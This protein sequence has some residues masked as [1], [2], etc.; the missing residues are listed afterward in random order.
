MNPSTDTPVRLARHDRVAVI[1]ID[2]PPV[3]ALS[4][5]VRQGL[6]DS[7]AAACRDPAVAAIVL[8]CSGK[9]FISGADVKEFGLVTDAPDGPSLLRALEQSDKPVICAMHGHALGGGLE[10]AL[11][12]HWR[13]AADGSR[14]GLPEITLGLLP[15]GGGTQRLPRLVGLDAA[16]RIVLS[17]R[18]VEAA[19]ALELGLL[20]AVVAEPL[21]GKAIAFA[22]SVAGTPLTQRRLSGRPAPVTDGDAALL[23]QQTA[24][25]SEAA[26]RAPNAARRCVE[27]LLASLDADA[28]AGMSRERQL[29]LASLADEESLALRY[30]FLAERAA[31][32]VRGLDPRL[33]PEP[34][35]RVSVVGAGTM[36][37]GIAISCADAGYEVDVIDVDAAAIERAEAAIAAHYTSAVGRRRMSADSAAG[38]LARF[39]Y[40]TALGAAADTDLVIEAIYEDLEAKRTMFRELDRTVRSGAVLVTNT[41]TLDVDRIAEATRRPDRVLGMHFFSP[42]N[43]MR[44]IEVVRAEQTSAQTLATA[45]ALGARLRKLCITVGV[46]DGFVGNRMSARRAQQIERM[47]QE[48]ALPADIDARIREFG[49]AM[50]PCAATDLAGLDV[51]WRIRKGKGLKSPIA[52]SLCERGRFGQKAG[53]GY[54]AYPDGGREPVPDP[55]VTLLI[56]EISRQNGIERRTI[57]AAEILDRLL[58]PMINEGARI[59]MEGIAERPGDIDLIWVNGF[60]W[61]ARRAGPMFYADNLGLRSVCDRLD[62]LA[63]TLRDPTMQPAGLLRELAASNRSF[64]SLQD[65]A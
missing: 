36:G 63:E 26:R 51:S 10:L 43:V 46:C 58:L 52:D 64:R 11:S 32:R 23:L 20:D 45:L 24:A 57:D 1:T 42:A 6:S 21:L 4:A 59:L 7:L 5:R 62:R 25:R 37:R 31:R 30:V 54:Y 12:C 53:R 18:P 22:E 16:A 55:E 41:S 13:I 33:A 39:R 9:S 34:V 61:P 8:I 35:R 17:G 19:E 29:F 40:G 28:A 38:S 27:A 47:L 49:F 56:E 3:N 48:G 2:N 14:F 60:G 15:G 65:A 50:G 44:L